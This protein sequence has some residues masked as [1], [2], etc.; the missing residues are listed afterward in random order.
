[1]QPLVK[2]D[3]N[4]LMKKRIDV[5]YPFDVESDGKKETILRWCQGVVIKVYE[6]KTKPVVS[7]EWDAMPDVDGSDESTISDVVLLP[8]KWK[9]DVVIALRMDVERDADDM[10]NSD[11]DSVCES[12]TDTESEGESEEE[13]GVESEI[14]VRLKCHCELWWGPGLLVVERSDCD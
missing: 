11:C 5:L 3:L 9:K 7:V 4:E 1:M 12:E 6:H 13:S 14:G 10:E 8:T 2:P